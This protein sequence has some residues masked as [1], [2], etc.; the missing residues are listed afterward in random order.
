MPSWR[1]GISRPWRSSPPWQPAGP[2]AHYWLARA[3]ATPALGAPEYT[4]AAGLPTTYYGQL[5][6]AALGDDETALLKRI[7]A[8]HDPGFDAARTLDLAGHEMARAAALLVSW[9]DGHGAVPFLLRLDENATDPQDHEV[10][11]RLALGFGLPEAAVAIARRLARDN[12]LLVDAGWPVGA[13]IPP[14]AGID[15][16]LAL[17]LIRQESSF[18]PDAASPAGARGLMQLMPATAA[19][20][21]RKIGLPNAALTDPADNIRLGTAHMQDLLRQFG[22]SV[23]LAVAAYNAGASR[24]REWLTNFG[25]PRGGGIDMVDWIELI[26]FT[27]TRNYVQRVLENAAIY[28]AHSAGTAAQAPPG[29]APSPTGPAAQATQ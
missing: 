3:A 26:P 23:P 19:Q 29:P 1:P 4:E 9:G 6:A 16:A 7:D 14:D 27:E 28:R 18:D 21:Q 22:G 5:A 17:A 25:D 20:L 15:P 2:R 24:V 13:D 10:A 11:A 8:L 12:L